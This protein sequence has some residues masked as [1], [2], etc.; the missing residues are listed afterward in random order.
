MLV[1]REPGMSHASATANVTGHLTDLADIL[2]EF[3]SDSP[4]PDSDD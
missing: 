1:E 2:L 3:R 4:I